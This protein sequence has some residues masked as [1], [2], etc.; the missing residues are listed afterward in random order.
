MK[1]LRLTPLGFACTCLAAGALAADTPPQPVNPVGHWSEYKMIIQS[2]QPLR[3]TLRQVYIDRVSWRTAQQTKQLPYGTKIALR[4]FEAVPDKGGWKLV[5]N[6][7][8]PGK[9]TTVLIQQKE[10]GWGTTHPENIRTGEWE[11]AIFTADGKQIPVDTEKACMPCHKQVVA[12]D[13]NFQV[14]R[15]LAE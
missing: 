1:H 14:S 7:L 10:K 15:F 12:T 4:D 11:F 3:G 5:N 13:Y 2:D 8:V 9:P 6:R